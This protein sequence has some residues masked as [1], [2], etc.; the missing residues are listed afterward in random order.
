MTALKMEY[1]EATGRFVEPEGQM[2][3]VLQKMSND[4]IVA[5]DGSVAEVTETVNTTRP[6]LVRG[7]PMK[8]VEAT[9]DPATWVGNPITT[10]CEVPTMTGT[11]VSCEKENVAICESCEEC[12]KCTWD[13]MCIDCTLNPCRCRKVEEVWAY[14]CPSCEEPYEDEHEAMSCCSGPDAG[15]FCKCLDC[16]ALYSDDGW[17][18]AHTAAAACCA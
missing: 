13:L 4:L 5:E 11:C 14:T 8:I 7:R 9:D 17:S 3:E 2:Q 16:G 10:C 6:R 12:Q 15:N 18:D 1:D